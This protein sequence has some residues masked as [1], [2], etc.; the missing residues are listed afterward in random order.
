MEEHNYLQLMCESLEKKSRVLSEIAELNNEQK[1]LLSTEGE[2]DVA[3]WKKVIDQK[4]EKIDEI[5]FLDSGFEELYQRVGK[6]LAQDHEGYAT[7]IRKMK[8]LIAKVTDQNVA[9]RAS[10]A[11]NKELAQ[12]Q[13]GKQK[14]KTKTMRQSSQV[15]KLYHDT[16]RKTNIVDAQFLDHKK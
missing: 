8:A 2:V 12:Q 1:M 5:N 16:M 14:K 15:A 3:S 10:E 4:A 11:R 9:I 6:A 13:F 7:E